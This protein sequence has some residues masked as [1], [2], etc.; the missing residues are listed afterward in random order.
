MLYIGWKWCVS[1]CENFLWESLS[2]NS[3]SLRDNS[4]WARNETRILGPATRLSI[5]GGRILF[6]F[7]FRGRVSRIF[8]TRGYLRRRFDLGTLVP[9]LTF[10]LFFFFLSKKGYDYLWSSDLFIFFLFLFFFYV[11]NLH[12]EI[13][14]YV[15][16]ARENYQI[17]N[18][19]GLSLLN[20]LYLFIVKMDLKDL[21]FRYGR[22]GDFIGN[23]KRWRR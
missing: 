5:F 19:V 12:Q 23:E 14:D 17:C 16:I 2:G 1:L 22:V 11:K 9:A 18:F 8:R 4:R 13:D 20:W 3:Y 21:F 15:N 6:F 7:F 10:F